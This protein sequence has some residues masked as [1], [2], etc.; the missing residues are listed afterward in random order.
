MRN[1]HRIAWIITFSGC[2]L[3]Q[4]SGWAWAQDYVGSDACRDCHDEQAQAW[5]GSHHA[6]AWTEPTSDTVVAD[7]DET[8]FSH[9]GMSVTF[10]QEGS[11]Y[12]A[13]VTEKDGQSR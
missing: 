8:T 1:W 12:L 4:N 11:D 7:F 2:A 5:E 9:D 10:R 13:D 3:L 6:L